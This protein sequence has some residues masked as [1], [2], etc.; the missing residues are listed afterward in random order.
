MKHLQE[1]RSDIRFG[2][3]EIVPL[4]NVL[5]QVE[6]LHAPV[7]VV[8]EQLVL[9][10]TDRPAGTLVTVVA[11]MGKVPVD[12]TPVMSLAAEGGQEADSVDVLLGQGGQAH[13]LEQSRV[14]IGSR[15]QGGRSGVGLNFARPMNN[16]R[17]AYSTLVVPAFGTPQGKV[18]GSKATVQRLPWMI[19]SRGTGSMR[20]CLRCLP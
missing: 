2:L 17:D 12:G 10:Q 3:G 6:E 9:P 19:D 7:F 16:Q 13:H 5:F 15:D 8:F 11:V 18:G 20:T 1:L 14:V 4:T